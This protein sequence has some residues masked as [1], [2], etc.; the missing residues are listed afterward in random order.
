[1]RV[2][3]LFNE[4]KRR[5]HFGSLIKKL[6]RIGKPIVPTTPVFVL[7]K[8]RSGTTMLFNYFESR[9]DTETYNESNGRIFTDFQLHPLPQVQELLSHSRAPFTV[10]KSICDSHRIQ[11]LFETFPNARIVWAQRDCKDVANS[12]IRHFPPNWK[13]G[14][15]I[16]CNGE[17]GG[18]WFVQGVSDS[19]A[20][21]LREVYSDSLSPFEMSCLVWWARNQIAVENK[22]D[23]HPQICMVQYE[24]LVTQPAK[25]FEDLNSALGLPSYPQAYAHVHSRS[26][27][28][29]EYPPIAED[30]QLMCKELQTTLQ[31]M[32]KRSGSIDSDKV[33]R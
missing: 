10:F 28:R 7:G 16:I 19:A 31:L 6:S 26:V 23:E 8:Q 5:R 12:S 17:S 27:G 3:S 21:R 25:S 11:E 18:G 2:L 1:M 14:L 13:T 15:Q 32:A 22:I 24:D 29:N 20:V 9:P 33:G 30:I 4:E